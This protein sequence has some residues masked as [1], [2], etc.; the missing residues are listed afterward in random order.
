M[1]I[2][3]PTKAIHC[4]IKHDY[5][6]YTQDQRSDKANFTRIYAHSGG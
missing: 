2:H 1:F 4:L 3:M 5:K 6:Y